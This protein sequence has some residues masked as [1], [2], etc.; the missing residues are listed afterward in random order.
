MSAF[1]P[2]QTLV[3]DMA[4]YLPGKIISTCT[5]LCI[6]MVLCCGPLQG[7]EKDSLRIYKKLKKA[8]YKHK[9]TKMAYDAVFVD[10]EPKEYPVEPA[11]KEKKRVNPYLK[12]NGRVI[13]HV[14]IRVFD[15]FG[16]SVNDTT[17]K[18]INGIQ[19]TGN[20]L[21]IT[22]RQW[23]IRNRLLFKENDTINPLALS[24]T[25]R[26]LREASFVNDARVFI[27]ETRHRD[28]VDV[29][30][31]VHDKWPIVAPVLIT[32]VSGNVRIRN[33]NLF[34]TGQQFEQYAG[35]RRPDL[36]ELNGYYRISN[37][38]NTYISSTLNYVHN[39][40]VTSVGLNFDRPFYSPLSE[41]AGGV[42]A[43]HTW[44]KFKVVDTLAQVTRSLPLNQVNYDVWIGKYFK[45]NNTKTLF[46]QSANIVAGMRYYSN[47]FVNRPSFEIDTANSNQNMSAFIGNVGFAVQQYYKDKFIYRFG[48][49]EDVPEG[50]ILQ[51]LY[52]GLKFEKGPLRYYNGIEI[53]RAKHFNFGYFTATFSYGVFY[54]VKIPN[55]VT[56]NYNIYYF[57]E[58]MKNGRW[59]FRQFLNYGVVHGENKAPGETI[60]FRS[61]DLYGFNNGVLA[62]NTKMVLNSETVAY[63]PYNVIGFRF[64]PVLMIGLGV[65]GD[66]QHRLTNSRL[67]QGY[68]LGIMLRNEN[69][70][71]S[72]FQFSFGYYPFL[73]NGKNNALL[74]NP[75][76]SFTL[77]VR[78]FSVNR[79]EFIAY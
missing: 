50:L 12:R 13:R 65:I 27:T 42:A 17:P 22:T 40:D 67:Y 73:P 78:A 23:I 39:V 47:V 61:E 9:L 14:N 16:Y 3:S 53:G 20:R 25:E 58:L 31:Y 21:H 68:S 32:D 37:I 52:G 55:D 57:S 45:L 62:G 11:S 74:Y 28:S 36:Y 41:W 26:V 44:R 51:F 46:N 66:P 71:T 2:A 64:A 54:N 10:P 1:L 6:L 38:D 70:L 18:R 43:G 30:V 33:K 19:R 76:T 35:F 75:V 72:T 8:F 29:N 5:A 59:F 7:Q 63:M 77:R 48:A 79:P 56:T 4:K 69:L 49:N 60:T 34:G 24:E 15:P